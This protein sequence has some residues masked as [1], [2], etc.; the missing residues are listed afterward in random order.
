MAPN[1][2]AKGLKSGLILE[3]K[4]NQ[5][6]KKIIDS[7]IVSYFTFIHLKTFNANTEEIKH[8]TKLPNSWLE[9]W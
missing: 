8:P 9:K 3:L 7:D 2:W 5:K 4:I 6:I 1:L